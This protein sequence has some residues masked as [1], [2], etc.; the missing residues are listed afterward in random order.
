MLLGLRY[1]TGSFSQT[2]PGIVILVIELLLDLLVFSLLSTHSFAREPQGREN[3]MLCK[4][5]GET[6]CVVSLNVGTEKSREDQ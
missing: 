2:F 5:A 6:R 1:L 3:S 4:Q